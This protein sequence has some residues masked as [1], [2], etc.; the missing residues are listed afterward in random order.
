MSSPGPTQQFV[1]S[2]LAHY[3]IPVASVAYVESGGFSGATVWEVASQTGER[4]AFKIHVGDREKS[5]HLDWVHSVLRRCV[6][7]GC[8]FVAA[9]QRTSQRR[10]LHASVVSDEGFVGELSV[11]AKGGPVDAGS[12]TSEKIA[13]AFESVGRFHKAAA[14]IGFDMRTSDGVASRIKILQTYG[15]QSARAKAELPA[16]SKDWQQ[17]LR[18]LMDLVSSVPIKQVAVFANA[19]GHLSLQA[20]PAQPVIRDLRAEHL[21]F[22]GDQLSGLIDF[23]AMAIDSVAWDLSRLIATMGLSDE[24]MEFAVD[25]YHAIRPLH[26]LDTSLIAVVVRAAPLIA[27]LQWVEWLAVEGRTFPSSTAVVSRLE[28]V[29]QQLAAIL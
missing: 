16:Q 25:R 24:Q 6:E 20:V 7:E 1:R 10:D 2:L 15:T 23:D 5:E 8:D 19:F 18:R 26:P 11:W 17:P 28:K 9:P 27:A 21:F 3:S 12:W 22:V 13:S 14:Q 4:F 29:H